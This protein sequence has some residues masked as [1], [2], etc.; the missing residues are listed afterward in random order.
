[1]QLGNA[2]NEQNIMDM[3]QDQDRL[4]QNIN[5]RKFNYQN[6]INIR[7]IETKGN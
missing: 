7:V 6:Q 3:L 5:N 2:V 1:M 4:V